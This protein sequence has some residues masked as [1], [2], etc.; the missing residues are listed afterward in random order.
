VLITSKAGTWERLINY[1]KQH[2]R[3]EHTATGN[4]KQ[5]S[6]PILIQWVKI[7]NGLD[8]MEDDVLWAKQ[9]DKYNTDSDEEGEDM[10]TRTDVGLTQGGFIGL[11]NRCDLYLSVYSS[12]TI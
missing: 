9:Y 8:G 2:Y 3:N 1:F 6:L 11:K 12:C 7:S 10:I 5:P 4:L